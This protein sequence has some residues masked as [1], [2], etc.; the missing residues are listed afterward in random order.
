MGQRCG[1]RNREIK[2]TFGRNGRENRELLTLVCPIRF[3][4]TI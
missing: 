2:A 1:A 3:F 4:V